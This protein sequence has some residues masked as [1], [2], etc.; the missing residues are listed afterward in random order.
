VGVININQAL[1]AVAALAAAGALI[2]RHRRPAATTKKPVETE[3]LT[4]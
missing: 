3:E 4:Q 2:W 1:M